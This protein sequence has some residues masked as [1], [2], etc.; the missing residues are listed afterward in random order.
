MAARRALVT[1]A[2]RG[3]G[4]EICKQLGGLGYRVVLT[5]RDAAQGEA[6]A[7]ELRAGGLAV[8]H[9]QLDVT[10]AA[11]V[12]ALRQWAEETGGVDALVNNA[13]VLLDDG[14]RAMSVSL[15]LV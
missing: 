6:A 5:S 10:D 9:R 1:G 11:S 14:V 15:D 12:A 8:E 7:A 3:I 13:G 4:L 2:N